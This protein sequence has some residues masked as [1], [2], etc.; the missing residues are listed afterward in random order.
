MSVLLDRP[1]R[2]RRGSPRRAEAR[3]PPWPRCSSSTAPCSAAGPRASPTSPPRWGPRTR[4]ARARVAV[5]VV[6]ALASM[7]L[8]GALCARLGAGLVAAASAVLICG[9]GHPARPGPLAARARLPRCSPSA[10]RRVRSTSPPTASASA[11]RPPATGRSCPGCMPGFSFGGLAGAVVGGLRLGRRGGCRTCSAWPR[12][13]LLLSAA[14][15]RCLVAGR[16]RPARAGRRGRR[17]DRTPAAAPRSLLVVLGLIAGCTAYGEG[18]ITDWGAL[19]LREYAGGDP[20][21]RRSRIRRV[22]AGDG[23]R[24]ARRAPG[25]CGPSGPRTCWSTARCWRR[26]ACSPPP[27]P[28]SPRWRWSGSRWSGWAWRTSSRSRSPARASLGGSKRGGAGVDRRLH[29]PARRPA[30]DRAARRRGRACRPRW[31]RCRCSRRS[32]RA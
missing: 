12:S 25:S 22:L 6:G 27:S 8:A 31:P 14:S 21:R 20:G 16:R 29:R 13:G 3:W 26:S 28:R 23:L 7:Q 30:R 4:H 1:R 11:S 9:G 10:R 19:H 5:R 32:P 24:A 2:A 18:A 17:A 15:R